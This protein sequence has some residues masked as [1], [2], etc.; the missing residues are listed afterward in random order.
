MEFIL[1]ALITLFFIAIQRFIINNLDKT[2]IKIINSQ[3]YIHDLVYP[4]SI[5][6]EQSGMK[7]IKNSQSYKFREKTQIKVLV[8]E[9]KAY[10]ITNNTVFVADVIDGEVDSP[11]AK[12]IDTM[13]MDSVQLDRM[14]FIVERLTEG[15]NNDY[16]GPR[17]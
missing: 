9:E 1:G 6:L 16:R 3:S 15:S 13:G 2:K 12:P 8:F 7:V 10:W 5:S 11:N 14:M 4:Y 17:Y